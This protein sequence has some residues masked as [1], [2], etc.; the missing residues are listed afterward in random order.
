MDRALLSQH[1]V[2]AEQHVSLCERH[3]YRQRAL[4]EHLAIV[5][6]D[7]GQAECLLQEFEQMLLMFTA[8]RDRVRA[9]LAR[10]DR[11]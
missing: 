1:L 7:T 4:V 2:Q 9:E 6:N 5:G 8:D 11:G 10:F 3:V